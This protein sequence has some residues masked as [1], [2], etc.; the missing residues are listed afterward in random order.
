MKFVDITLKICYVVY[1]MNFVNFFFALMLLLDESSFKLGM[2]R[3]L[4]C[5][6]VFV[7]YGDYLIPY[8]K[9]KVDKDAGENELH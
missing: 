9:E 6:V 8:W 3:S 4:L 7:V 2:F 5:L 1:Y